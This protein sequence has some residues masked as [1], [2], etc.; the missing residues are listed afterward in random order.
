MILITS[1]YK[2]EKKHWSSDKVNEGLL[3]NIYK[4][5]S[6]PRYKDF[7]GEAPDYD[8]W[9]SKFLTD[10]TVQANVFQVLREIKNKPDAKFIE[11]RDKL[12]LKGFDAAQKEKFSKPLRGIT[13]I[14]KTI[15]V[16]NDQYSDTGIKF[17]RSGKKRTDIKRGPYIE[18]IMPGEKTGKKFK[19]PSFFGNKFISELHGNIKA[20]IASERHPSGEL[21]D[22]ENIKQKV[23]EIV[24]SILD[25]QKQ[26][27]TGAYVG[28]MEEGGFPRT[29]RI[30][31][32]GVNVDQE[33]ANELSKL[34]PDHTIEPSHA[35]ANAIK[36]TTPGGVTKTFILGG[37]LSSKKK[38]Q[39]SKQA[40]RVGDYGDAII[41]FI[42]A[43]PSRDIEYHDQ[44]IK[45]EDELR[46]TITPEMIKDFTGKEFLTNVETNRKFKRKVYHQVITPEMEDKYYKLNRND[47]DNISANIFE[48]NKTLQIADRDAIQKAEYIKKIED[49]KISPDFNTVEG[50]WENYKTTNIDHMTNPTEKRFAEVYLQLAN[51]EKNKLT[52]SE[53][54]VLKSE[55]ELLKK[56]IAEKSNHETYLDYSTG[57]TLKRAPTESIWEGGDNIE[58]DIRIRQMVLQNIV[59]ETSDGRSDFEIIEDRMKQHAIISS[60]FKLDM[61]ETLM[62]TLKHNSA[63]GLLDKFP[64]QFEVVGGFISDNPRADNAPHV[65][66]LKAKWKDIINK[67]KW[68]S[69]F[70]TGYG[71][72][73]AGL[74]TPFG[75][76]FQQVNKPY[77]GRPFDPGAPGSM[78]KDKVPENI[79]VLN[80]KDLEDKI[81][82]YYNQQR[83]IAIDDEVLKNM[84]FLNKD[85]TSIDKEI[86]NTSFNDLFYPEG[87][88]ALIHDIV[89]GIGEW[90]PGLFSD[91]SRMLALKSIVG[92]K[93]ARNI[94]PEH[95]GREIVDAQFNKMGILG[96]EITPEIEAF[97]K[98]SFGE[99]VTE[100]VAGSA[101][102]LLSFAAMNWGAGILLAAKIPGIGRSIAGI[103]GAMRATRY[104]TYS[105]KA[106]K[107]IKVTQA[108]ALELYKIDLAAAKLINPKTKFSFQ[109]WLS[110]VDDAGNLLKKGRQWKDVGKH[111]P[112]WGAAVLTEAAIEG[113]K[114]EAI[115]GEFQTGFGFGLAG[116]IFTPFL[117]TITEKSAIIPGGQSWLA[118]SIRNNVPRWEK[119]YH[120]A[121][122]APMT[123][124]VGSELGELTLALSDDLM[125]VKT[126]GNFMDEH[127]G[128][129]SEDSKRLMSN[130][131]IG[132]AFG[133]AHVQRW[134][135]GLNKN[136]TSMRGLE[137]WRTEAQTKYLEA[138]KKLGARVLKDP[139]GVKGGYD[140]IANKAIKDMAKAEDVMQTA[141]HQ[142]LR[143]QGML[144]SMNPITAQGKWNRLLKTHTKD[145][146]DK[147]GKESKVKIY[148]DQTM[149]KDSNGK[150]K[151]ADWVGIKIDPKTKKKI[152]E[153]IKFSEADYLEYRVNVDRAVEGVIMH[154]FGHHALSIKME[155][156]VFSH[157]FY[158]DLQKITGEIKFPDGRTLRQVLAE[159]IKGW[160]EE[161][162]PAEA[163]RLVPEEVFNYITQELGNKTNL[164]ALTG[165]RAFWKLSKF[166]EGKTGAKYDFT[167]IQDVRRWFA[168]Y[169]ET[170]QKGKSVFKHL[171]HLDVVMEKS[172][173]KEIERSRKVFEKELNTKIGTALERALGAKE[174]MDKLETRNKYL[175]KK[176]FKNGEWTDPK[177]GAEH[178][179]NVEEI[180]KLEE[181]GKE[182]LRL[183]GIKAKGPRLM[184]EVYQDIQNEFDASGKDKMDRDTA[185]MLIYKHEASLVNEVER[186]LTGEPHNLKGFSKT[187][188]GEIAHDFLYS[189]TRGL[190]KEFMKYNP[191]QTK[192]GKTFKIDIFQYLNTAPAGRTKSLFDLRLMEFYTK[193][194]EYNRIMKEISE[195]TVPG[196]ITP[197]ELRTEADQDRFDEGK[198]DSKETQHFGMDLAGKESAP[199]FEYTNKK[200][201]KVI[202]TEL[203][204]RVVDN[205]IKSFEK[206]TPEQKTKLDFVK[207]REFNDIVSGKKVHKIFTA[208]E[209]GLTDAI[210]GKTTKERVKNASQKWELL[211]DTLPYGVI[212][213]SGKTSKKKLEGIEGRSAMVRTALQTDVITGKNIYYKDGKRVVSEFDATGAAVTEKIKIEGLNKSQFLEP[214]GVKSVDVEVPFEGRYKI[215]KRYEFD[216]T[217]PNNVK[218]NAKLRQG[219]L[220]NEINRSLIS[221]VLRKHLK[222]NYTGNEAAFDIISRNQVI[223]ALAAGKSS[224]L[225]SETLV[226]DFNMLAR[227]RGVKEIKMGEWS[228]AWNKLIRNPMDIKEKLR[229]TMYDWVANESAV[230]A[231]IGKANQVRFTTAIK[232]LLLKQIA[233]TEGET[234]EFYKKLLKGDWTM[235]EAKFRMG[236]EMIEGEGK[237]IDNFKKTALEFAK[238]MP[239]MPT[240]GHMGRWMGL[241]TGHRK[242]MLSEAKKDSK[243]MI[244]LERALKSSPEK[245]IYS[246]ELTNAFKNIDW[247]S[248]TNIYDSK[249]YTLQKRLMSDPTR[250]G[251]FIDSKGNFRTEAEQ[252]KRQLKI[253]REFFKDGDARAQLDIINSWNGMMET[254]VHENIKTRAERTDFMLRTQ[255]HNGSIG[256][257]GLRIHAPIAYMMMPGSRFLNYKK[258]SIYNE[259]LQDAKNATVKIKKDGKIE[260]VKK[261]KSEKAENNAALTRFVKNVS[262][263][264]HLKSS[265]EQSFDTA[266]LILM[267]Q[268]GSVGDIITQARYKSVFGY[269]EVFDVIDKDGTTNTADIHRFSR[270]L[271]QAKTTYSVESGLKRTLYDD[272]V[273]DIA[274]QL[275][276]FKSMVEMQKRAD[277]ENKKLYS[278]IRMNSENLGPKFNLNKGLKIID[279]ALAKGR[280]GTKKKKGISVWD[281]DDTLI[282]T[283]SG[284]RV[285][286]PNPDMTVK[287]GKKVIF[288]AGGAG[289]GKSN[290]IKQLGL[291]KDFKIV[292]SDI[293]LVWLKK[294]H[295]LPEN[296]NDLTS[297]QLSTLGKLQFKSYEIAKEKMM[298][299]QGK[300]DGI[301]VDGT[302]GSYKAMLEKVKAFKDKGYD[303]QMLFVE[304]SLETA[305]ARNKA[306]KERSL[307]DNIIIKN[308]GKVQGNK[309]AF[310]ELF[311]DNFAEVKTDNL[312][313]G[314]PMPPE[315][316]NKVNRFTKSYENRRLTAEEFANEG[317]DILDKNGKFDFKEFDVIK[318]GEKGPFFNKAMS[319]IKKFGNKDNFILTARPHAAKE[320]IHRFLKSL[321]LE[322]P[323]ENIA[324]LENSTSEAKAMWMLER[325]AEGYNDFYFADDAIKNVEAVKNTL[326]Q[327]DVKSKVQQ[328]NR[329][330][331]ENLGPDLNK[332][333][334]ESRDIGKEKI[335]SRAKATV[336]GTDPNYKTVVPYSVMDARQLVKPMMGKGKKGLKHEKWWRENF[337][338][339]Y[340]RGI[341]DLN[342]LKS[343]IG[344]DYQ[345]LLKQHPEVRNSLKE[346]IKGSDFTWEQALR[347]HRFT[348][349]GFDMV[350]FGLSK[351]ELKN[352]NEAIESNPEF[353][354]FSERLGQITRIPEGYI[355]PNS[356][357]WILETISTDLFRLTD[358]V[359]RKKALADWIG[360]KNQIFTPENI[361]KLE[362]T[363]GKNYVEAW[364]D[365]LFR[366]EN[367]T[368][369]N[370]GDKK[371][372]HVASNVI[373]ATVAGVMFF[374][375]RS[376]TLQLISTVNY[377]NY[378]DNNIFKAGKAF[379][380][381]PQFLKDFRHIWNSDMLVQRRKGLRFDIAQQEIYDAVRFA[382]NKPVAL[383]RWMLQKGYIP[384]KYA[385]SFAIAMGGASYFR[386]RTKTYQKEGVSL[387]EAERKAWEDFSEKTEERQQSSRP[388]FIS[389]QQAG[390][391]GRMFLNWGN[392]P[393][394]MFRIQHKDILDL[395]AGR[396]DS[397]TEGTN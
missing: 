140:K 18:V 322:I 40:V 259:Y 306:R 184:S 63:R 25:P 99:T 266:S 202:D 238:S 15:D 27:W 254:F 228:M 323:I 80:K 152:G 89:P 185:M 147:Y 267:K 32:K 164:K 30:L 93:V 269:L 29:A 52:T 243:F 127:Y 213:Y 376:A 363:F 268:Y 339:P 207:I 379:A 298:K 197:K 359:L 315:L 198:L 123:F 372:A 51:A 380:N 68:F 33:I 148:N 296:M 225:N 282:R 61:E 118:R 170:M 358:R 249:Y 274:P 342:I 353:R 42:E 257:Q 318:E 311:S 382:P 218:T 182:F 145:A 196:R 76:E 201:E 231:Q 239:K 377:L 271:E 163:R 340:S 208:L 329:L 183:R 221:Q 235:S 255:K 162:S 149:P 109:S 320:A 356:H 78:A 19:I 205:I 58:N 73:G 122:K 338:R 39:F 146:K 64:G 137:K 107:V 169:V 7:F 193:L 195:I 132:A 174:G 23:N 34:F 354:V 37:P 284:V 364:Q 227:E 125:G 297:K 175:E 77:A 262:K 91:N 390:I 69:Q 60:E 45:L 90:S 1:A 46:T 324:T 187:Q 43:N 341:N 92:E 263:V 252:I 150:P 5:L 292:D 261:Y 395:S 65:V 272:I 215:E 83:E 165:S 368:N 81:E 373:N 226:K 98:R 177:W 394:Q 84:Y 331:S 28:E 381:L 295:G 130:Y 172:D 141:S 294:N 100:G 335:F 203:R 11:W 126:W 219:I 330:N 8:T 135:P 349:A 87:G 244:E 53:V 17:V 240:E 49:G 325:F 281:L 108:K 280:I 233:I 139:D 36:I 242:T 314:D 374:N 166:I 371:F 96:L 312:K 211:Y 44:R 217:L 104:A 253:A 287:P 82:R 248:T 62:F 286:I 366:M 101:G 105:K 159:K 24:T 360:K 348:K 260:K 210:W 375:V 114:F 334:E 214:L 171:D 111:I 304:T 138:A 113:V 236:E 22:R 3:S 115:G 224:R 112:S 246:K 85:I 305:L 258:S 161:M 367:N 337:F 21:K 189:E 20:Y 362:A 256:Q 102:I 307:L 131:I 158:K 283:K 326:N 365:M 151:N 229:N 38:D 2:P 13:Q 117:G 308:H 387:K 351:T 74:G 392:T 54:E 276:R 88:R 391:A 232:G 179:K 129:W 94:F 317:K 345:E 200:G 133:L 245:N 180:K 134:V 67:P 336:R 143:H 103:M 293:S 47:F 209:K 357:E 230:R 343:K 70:T 290:V 57:A 327:L 303:T 41:D 333:L 95:T 154:E 59:S 385:D 247:K 309:K 344:T 191:I 361:N 273:R 178:K 350:D 50:F 397:Y 393:M 48:Y 204:D 35:G 352:L 264:E 124:A 396:F 79:V 168:D 106:G 388:D 301:V 234:K 299:F 321:G 300:G 378:G 212:K 12:G 278:S 116:R 199:L 153:T 9:K 386:N 120:L 369:R 288:L 222:N 16:L 110:G 277:L 370:F 319:R 121:F 250:G 157:S 119:A 347:V 332:M 75:M 160:G 383:L 173:P 31:E 6:D 144:D 56:Q 310:K 285:K 237:A 4:T 270:A 275:A 328:S 389:Q 190:L 72:S 265:S 142:I 194:P 156:K 155:N 302:G 313:I 14:N 186:K 136:W 355:K 279:E 223:A 346:K 188:L 176:Y 86:K 71:A 289:S 55:Y 216:Q 97:A 291:A 26:D 241:F 181:A 66:T 251:I 316:T 10:E 384:T 206:L 220:F 167:K 192:D 128:D